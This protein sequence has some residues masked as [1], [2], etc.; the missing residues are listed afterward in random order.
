MI[1]PRMS[2]PAKV[3]LSG[4][5]LVVAALATAC[6]TEKVSVPSSEVSLHEG[7]VLFNQRCGGCHT[8]AYAGTHGSAQNVRTAQLNNGPNFDIRCERPVARVLYAIENGGFSGVV[9]PQNIVVGQQARDVAQFVATYSGRKAP[10]VPGV[11]PCEQVSIG[12]LEAA[13]ATPTTA[14]TTTTP[15]TTTP[16]TTTPTTT[17][18]TNTSAAGKS[19]FTSAGCAGCH[20]F[21]AAGASGTI[22]PNLDTRLRSDCATPASKRI[23]GATLNKCIHTAITD[24]Y[25][26][27]PSGYKAGIMPNSFGKT[28]TPAQLQALVSFIQSSAK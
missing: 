22:G 10:K 28:L 14:T 19:V 24:P 4:V 7:A 6:G 26:Y 13:L 8:F 5:L 11:V 25:A 12:S 9:M 21:A 18:P 23:R 1:P 3:L 20:T 15:T 16:T 27:L 2:R 17:T